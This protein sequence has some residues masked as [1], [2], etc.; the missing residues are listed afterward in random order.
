M[1]CYIIWHIAIF[2]LM[3]W[4][5]K[6]CTYNKCHV[7]ESGFDVSSSNRSDIFLFFPLKKNLGTNY[8]DFYHLVRYV[9]RSLW[10]EISPNKVTNSKSFK[11]RLKKKMEIWMTFTSSKLISYIKIFH[12]T[13]S[14]QKISL[15]SSVVA[16]WKRIQL[17]SMKMWVWSL[18]SLSGLRDLVL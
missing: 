16:Q 18:A 1:S 9:L 15:W 6:S 8:F 5:N 13:L 7:R 14:T 12:K 3:R 10:T 2:Q 4:Q 11:Q 17:V